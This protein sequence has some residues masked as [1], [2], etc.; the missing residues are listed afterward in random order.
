MNALGR[1]WL[2]VAALAVLG[3]EAGAAEKA[4]AYDLKSWP[5]GRLRGVNMNLDSCSITREDVRH[6]AED[7]GANHVR[8]QIFTHGI[9]LEFG[10]PGK[11]AAAYLEQKVD[12]VVAWCG[13][14]G[15][16]VVLDSHGAPGNPK[17]W[18]DRP[19]WEDFKWHENFVRL[20]REIAAHYR[21]N[22]TVVAYELLN[23]PNM[24]KEVE[25]APSDWLPL[26]KRLTAAI[27]EVDEYHTIVMTP[28]NWSNPG[29]FPR[30]E[31]TGDPNTIYTFHMYAPHSFTHQGIRGARTGIS[32]PNM[33]DGRQLDKAA[34]QR[35]L[36]PALDFQ[37][38]YGLPRLYCG[39]FSAV[40]WAPGDSAYNY[41]RDVLDIFEASGWDWAYHAYRESK[42]WSLEH[43]APD[44]DHIQEAETTNR[45]ELFL[46]HFARNAQD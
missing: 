29:A 40:I 18:S 3:M 8:L 14:F 31:P 5:T 41:L 10:E 45:L 46:D 27:R 20:W 17:G 37:K 26:A 7:W 1:F 43:E 36:Q 23:E 34:L 13:E 15:L 16:S 6:L 38:E 21:D 19:L 2:S 32:Y 44:P 25:G 24:K 42:V 12:P 35:I 4:V 9:P 28:V 30:L 22:R 11:S 39:E 33:E